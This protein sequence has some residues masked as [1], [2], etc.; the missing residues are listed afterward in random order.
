MS[1][2]I[3]NISSDN[4]SDVNGPV[5]II[6]IP[7]SAKSFIFSVTLLEK[8]AL[9]TAKAWPAGTAVSSAIFISNESNILSSSFNNPQ[10]FVCKF[11][12]KELLH[13]I[14]AKFS[15]ECAGEN[16]C[17]FISYNLTLIPFFAI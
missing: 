8:S 16:F 9:S 5:A 14:S 2:V 6:T 17:G 12:L 7:S 3:C 1:P 4:L 11:D 13:T 10:A 15:F